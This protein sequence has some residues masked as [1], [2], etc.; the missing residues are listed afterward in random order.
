MRDDRLQSQAQSGFEGGHQRGEWHELL[1]ILHHHHHRFSDAKYEGAISETSY[2]C[3]YKSII[4]G[5][6]LFILNLI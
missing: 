5:F 1:L 4:T 6:N 2:V 3:S